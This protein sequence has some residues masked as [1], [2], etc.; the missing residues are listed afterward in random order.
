MTEYRDE[1]VA[2]MSRYVPEVK[3]GAAAADDFGDKQKSAALAARRMGLA[4]AE[5]GDK[6]ARAQRKAA[7]AAK[8]YEHAA[9]EAADASRMLARGGMEEAEAAK[10]QE[11]AHKAGERAADAASRAMRELERADIAQTA[12]AM[13]SAK[14]T[15]NQADQMRQLARSSVSSMRTAEQAGESLFQ[16]ISG[17]GVGMIALITAGLAALPA[18]AQLAG[19]AIATGVGG[20]LIALGLI[21]SKSD[22]QVQRDLHATASHIKTGVREISAP[23]KETWHTVAQEGRNVWDAFS[24][25]LRSDF[26]VLAPAASVFTRALGD[27]LVRMRPGIDA[28]SNG[29]ASLLRAISAGLPSALAAIGSSF[30]R[31]GKTL[32]KNPEDV[33]RLVNGLVK[34]GAGLLNTVNYLMGVYHAF[35]EVTGMFTHFGSNLAEVNSKILAHIPIL[36]EQ[37]RAT[38]LA[39]LAAR[40][41]TGAVRGASAAQSALN[42]AQD[43]AMVNALAA[44]GQFG[45]EEQMLRLASQSAK[46]LKTSL[47][48]LTGKELTAREAAANYGSSI[49]AMNKALKENG[50]Q[51]GFA[52][53]KGIANE[54]ALTSL[55]KAAQDN[56]VAMRNDGKSAREVSGYMEGA[57]KRIIAAA[58]GM[59]YSRKEAIQL[60]N[61]LSGVTAAAKRVPKGHRISYPVGGNTVGQL[62]AITSW[63]NTAARAMANALAQSMRL[64]SGGY[65]GWANGGPAPGFADG[66]QVQRFP[67]G[68]MVRGPGTGTSDSIDARLSNGEYVINAAATAM[69]RPVLDA[70]NYGRAKPSATSAN[71]SAHTAGAGGAPV[72]NIYVAGHVT[73]DRKLV[74]YVRQQLAG[75]SVLSPGHNGTL[76]ARAV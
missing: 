13:A 30:E 33:A 69:W 70:I 67:V 6:A 2:D 47:D 60:A 51:H 45:H 4:A 57:R 68:G 36:G 44:A 15:D 31:I 20:G 1:Y 65:V 59:G 18:A 72:V 62:Q 24:E 66:G 54:Q 10:Y 39:A 53:S 12:A 56:A 49:L 38:R 64:A 16:R 46:D 34:L 27:G 50:R 42:I 21:A 32:E 26:Q 23:F 28:L 73:S 3:R 17:S 48:A 22:K 74:E 61:K 5:A 63:A 9:K 8:I 11:R 58:Q 25:H 76:T 75:R 14:A 71:A 29:F 37:E 52:T 7:D 41:H 19:G 55:A 40:D 43:A 35:A